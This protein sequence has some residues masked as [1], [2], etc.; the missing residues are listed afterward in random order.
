M[1][2]KITQDSV[3]GVYNNP[4]N[5]FKCE[6]PINALENLRQPRQISDIK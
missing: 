2:I 1:L 3:Y 6:K 5:Y 4:V